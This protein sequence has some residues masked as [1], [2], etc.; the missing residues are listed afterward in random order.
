V[1]LAVVAGI[2]WVAWSYG[3]EMWANVALHLS[4]EDTTCHVQQGTVETTNIDGY[5]EYFPR[6]VLEVPAGERRHRAVDEHRESRHGVRDGIQ[7][8]V[9]A[10]V[11]TEQPCW[12][13]PD[14]P[15]VATLRAPSTF[16]GLFYVGLLGA[17][18]LFYLLLLGA[19]FGAL[20]DLMK[21]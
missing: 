8:R 15:T 12:Y 13:D 14:D 16:A 3:G 11:G 6:F 1:C 17:L 21:R 19:A 2:T 20:R 4:N 10:A 5:T 9:D 18:G 7:E